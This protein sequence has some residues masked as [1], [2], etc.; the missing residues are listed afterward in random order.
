[1]KYA[2]IEMAEKTS[3][4][5]L[6]HA[7]FALQSRSSYDRNTI[8][9]QREDGLTLHINFSLNF[10]SFGLK[11][12]AEEGRFWTENISIGTMDELLHLFI[13]N[14]DDALGGFNWI[15]RPIV[16]RKRRKS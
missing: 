7:F 15:G 13:Y 16:R 12:K 6:L 4:L 1:M 2:T 3:Y 14:Q 5:N 11:D 9:F 8:T 10:L